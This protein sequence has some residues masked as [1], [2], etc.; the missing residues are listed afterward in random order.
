MNK[1]TYI[2]NMTDIAPTIASILRLPPPSS[3]EGECIPSVYSDLCSMDKVCLIGIDALGWYIFNERRKY[4]PFLS[5]MHDKCSHIISSIMPTITPVNFACMVTGT[6]ANV[7]GAK[8]FLHPI[9]C[10]SLFD[11]LKDNNMESAG[12]GI[13]AYTGSELLGRHATHRILYRADKDGYYDKGLPSVIKDT[14]ETINPHFILAQ[15]GM[16]DTVMHKFGPS[17]EKIIPMLEKTDEVLSVIIPYLIKEGYGVIVT[18][19][20]GQ[21]DT[22]KGGSHGSAMASDRLVPLT[23]APLYDDYSTEFDSTKI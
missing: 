5:K 20:H 21:H 1:D 7:H 10:Q 14:V 4:M 13:K 19:D 16:P 22:E 17:S 2:F 8:T 18:S 6:N 23:W 3:S 12:I 15:M 11:I 9:K